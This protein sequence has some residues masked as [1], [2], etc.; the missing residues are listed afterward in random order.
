MPTTYNSNIEYTTYK[1]DYSPNRGYHK[2]LF[3]SGRP[4]QARELNELQTII[5]R[6]VAR[7]GGHLFKQGAAVKPG[8]ISVNNAYE[9]VRLQSSAFTTSAN[10]VGRDVTGSTSGVVAQVIQFVPGTEAAGDLTNVPTIYVRYKNGNP[11][12]ETDLA[13]A[14]GD[15]NS[16]P[17]PVKF[18]PGE[19]LTVNGGDPV[20]VE[21]S[22]YNN[23]IWPVGFGSKL[24]VGAGHYF[25]LGHFVEVPKQAV[26]LSKYFT[27][28]T[29]DIGFVVYQDIVT[30]TDSNLLYDNQGSVPNLTSPGADRYRI[31]LKLIKREDTLPSENFIFLA[32]IA[33]GVIAQATTG[34]NEYNKI[35][36]VL[37]QRTAEE[38]GN[39][40]VEPYKIRF[41]EID[42]AAIEDRL[43]LEVSKGVSYIN[44]YR[45][46]NPTLKKLVIPKP[47]ATETVSGDVVPV[48][49][50]RYFNV[51]STD[52]TTH[53]G[54]LTL[55]STVNLY[56]ATGGT[57]S[58]IGNVK[59]RSIE[60]TTGSVGGVNSVTRVYISSSG[61]I[62]SS[63]RS[64]KSIGTGTT[65][66]FDLVLEGSP[67][68]AV[69]KGDTKNKDLLFT[70]PRPRPSLVGGINGELDYNFIT[71]QT[72]TTN[73]SGEASITTSG[74]T[75]TDTSSWIVSSQ[76]SGSVSFIVDATQGAPVGTQ[77]DFTNLTPNLQYTTT[78]Y[79]R[80]TNATPKQ[81]RPVETTITGTVVSGTPFNLQQYDIKTV[82]EIKDSANGNSI[83]SYFTLD[84]GQRDTHYAKG[85]LVQTFP[86]SGPIYTKFE[87]WE[88]V[89]LPSGGYY[90][91]KNS[92]IDGPSI[93]ITYNDIPSYKP[94]NDAATRLFNVLDFRPDFDSVSG[95]YDNG[96]ETFHLPKR[97][98]LIT[99]DNS[100]YLPRADKLVMSQEGKLMYIRGVPDRNPQF[101]KTP[102]KSLELY[103]VV[104]NA[105]TLTPED[106]SLTKVEH[107]LYTMKDIGK[108]EK[109]LDRLEE[110]TALSLLEVDTKNLSL[111]DAD[112]NIRTK[113]GFFVENFKDQTL[114]ATKSKDYRASLDFQSNVARPKFSSDNIRL[115]WDQA[116]SSGV[117]KKG[118][119][120]YL[121]YAEV[122]WKSVQIASRNEPVNP[123]IINTFDGFMSL[124]PASDEWKDT[125]YKAPKI[126]PNGTRIENTD[127]GFIWNEHE[128]NWSGQNPD[129]LEVGQ[130]TGVNSTISDSKSY[131]VTNSTTTDGDGLFV[132]SVTTDTTTTN[133]TTTTKH[134]VTKIVSEETIEE[135]IGDRI[136]QVYSIPWMRSRKIYFKAEGLRPS[137]RVFPF[138]NN[139]N[140][141]KWCRQESF[142]LFSD[143][144][145]DEGNIN[146]QYTQHPDGPTTLITNEFGEVAGSFLI[147]RVINPDLYY[148]T[149]LGIET[150]DPAQDV[151]RF[152]AGS[153][154]FKLLDITQ[155]LDDAATARAFSVYSAKGALNQRQ[156]DV[157]STRVLH[158]ASSDFYSENSHVST[159]SSTALVQNETTAGQFTELLSTVEDM[160]SE[161]SSLEDQIDIIQEELDNTEY[162]IINNTFVTNNVTNE[163]TNVTNA[164]TNNYIT[165]ETIVITE[166]SGVSQDTGNKNEDGSGELAEGTTTIQPVVI[167]EEESGVGG[168]SSGT[169]AVVTTVFNVDNGGEA[170][171]G[172]A[173]AIDVTYEGSGSNEVAT[174]VLTDGSF[175]EETNTVEESAGVQP[176]KTSGNDKVTSFGY[177]KTGPGNSPPT[178]GGKT[179]AATNDQTV[180]TNAGGEEV[181]VYNVDEPDV[182]KVSTS[183]A[184]SAV[185]EKLQGDRIQ[186]FDPI[187]Q[188]FMVDNEYGTFITK[189]GLFFATKDPTIPV[190]VQIRPT[191]NGVPSSSKIIASKFV[192]SS[193][194]Q[195]PARADFKNFSVV[196][197]NETVFE[198]DEP[199]FLS[200]FTEYAICVIAPNT[201]YYTVY[202]SEM[203]QYVL[204]STSERILTQPSLGSFF[205]SQNS[206]LWEPDQQVDMMYKLYRAQFRYGGKAVFRNADV[207]REL[208]DPDP[209]N[210]TAGSNEVYVNHYDH[211]LRVG[212]KA[213]LLG[214]DS[215]TEYGGGTGILGGSM[216]TINGVRRTVTKADTFGY[217]FNADSTAPTTST[218]G[219][220][221]ITSDRN[222]QFNIANL[223]IETVNP[224]AT[225]ISAGYK[226]TT[227]SSIAGN[228][229]SYNKNTQWQ[230]ITPKINTSFDAPRQIANRYNETDATVGFEQR[231]CE[232][233]VD[234]KSSHE[235]ISPMLDLQ[236]CSLTLI[237]N[238]VDFQ[239]SADVS[240][241]KNIPIRYTSETDP[242][243]G[244]HPAKHI[245]KPISLAEDAVGLKV[246]YAA[247]IPSNTEIL[248]YYRTSVDGEDITTKNWIYDAPE[249][250]L[251]TDENPTIFREYTNLMGGEDGSL[252]AFNE[253]Q[254]KM[255]FRSKNSS[256]V[257]VIRD[258]RA[259]ALVD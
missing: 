165:N 6:E 158:E 104:M 73:G 105:N 239:D 137:V 218:F 30:A 178:Q 66:Y 78:L 244:S 159:T 115:I 140:V 38:S 246:L 211:G 16:G 131:D 157:L 184:T 106:L 202:V 219:G 235:F 71:Q 87:H 231:S 142:V 206:Q 194:V 12:S 56:N 167:E 7:L 192:A 177:V 230:R 4:L 37:A 57:G 14:E 175:D 141:S 90:Y 43:Y 122:N 17:A 34:L 54:T 95:T 31:R 80:I 93:S 148:K 191:V 243:S 245:T 228:Q 110:V 189:V 153:L 39:Y 163:Y 221:G 27:G 182:T 84:N 198:F 107:K 161:I 124:S 156:K 13:L 128:T 1:D 226:F 100:Y 217:A 47:T 103:K 174:V 150:Y 99:G 222:I 96:T 188:T 247:N 44:G 114:S 46:E 248:L 75:Y 145:E 26:I 118:D 208:L 168:S 36:D 203:E 204:G 69:I 166:N 33:N 81:K 51:N 195:V 186:Y 108:L 238:I 119:M 224:D 9:Y 70:L 94:T 25:V 65:N 179:T 133:T 250:T 172:T 10:L 154:E 254:L 136:V 130:V 28:F 251:P 237:E 123:F 223:N 45:T 67:L 210:T 169:Q 249:N 74:D 19:I 134:T 197:D 18:S 58:V 126:I 102:D 97:A 143:R 21:N 240:N 98:T 53:R 50:D 55:G 220:T 125:K 227:G 171:V 212:D 23:L 8:G 116:N 229:T 147:P 255:V 88:R 59:V 242:Y 170:V 83:F 29:G 42:S 79:K 187:A 213:E 49:Y 77:A 205:R 164:V 183:Q 252:D 62:S 258:L 146:T 196:K 41:V 52:N 256:K 259:I 109:K 180:F 86:Y 61:D 5:Q 132:E 48:V 257:P 85:R 15:D 138:F 135:V 201:P 144:E 91:S 121:D 63:I 112:G 214:L 89:T 120:L 68:R 160:T 11:T 24:G 232:I 241:F 92:Y 72:F 207:P 162:E 113:S 215:S 22:N 181:S 20:S 139:K 40:I 216:L 185:S 190:Q 209:I 253:F 155:P 199:V 101:K 82:S 233:K 127:V 151:D 236:R 152:P 193:Q 149:I 76:D 234:L 117:I 111:L 225:S 200:P 60:R 35:N 176:D 2:V 129:D 64:A 32:R 173:N 3:N